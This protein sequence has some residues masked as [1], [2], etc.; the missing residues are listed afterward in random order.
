MKTVTLTIHPKEIDSPILIGSRILKNAF[1]QLKIDRY[2]CAIV[3]CTSSIAKR[4]LPMLQEALPIESHAI[5]RPGDEEDKTLESV[6]AVWNEMLEKGTDR[7][8]IVLNFGGGVIGDMGGFIASTYMRGIDFIQIPTTLLAMVDA[9]IGGKTGINYGSVKN[10]IGT[11]EQPKGVIIETSFL[12]TLPKR[13]LISGWGEIVKYGLIEDPR[14]FETVTA[15]A[16]PEFSV[17]E[18]DE[19]I[20]QSCEIKTLLVQA[21]AQESG[22]RKKL[23]FGHTLGHALEAYSYEVDQPLTHGEAI[24]I[25]MVGEA[26]ISRDQGMISDDIFDQIE[27]GIARTGLPIRT[28]LPT[29]NLESILREKMAHDK[30]TVHGSIHWTLLKGIG[31]ADYNI[32]VGDHF[33]SQ[34]ITY[35]SSDQE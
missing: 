2:S 5:I 8:S 13:Q 16:A 12:E 27:S 4:W 26:L 20:R 24:A 29:E 1:H 11:I 19:I 3:F 33:I 30:K 6:S 32:V 7:H 10:I 35:I 34:A 18:I 14:L 31:E 28:T 15:K 25:G 21:D 23:N 17:S 9:S 22:P